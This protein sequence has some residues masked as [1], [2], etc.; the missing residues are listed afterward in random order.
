MLVLRICTA[1]MLLVLS[2]SL[3]WAAKVPYH[4]KCQS[5]CISICQP[6]RQG[7]R[8]VSSSG[9]WGAFSTFLQLRVCEGPRGRPSRQ[10]RPGPQG[11]DEMPGQV[12]ATGSFH[13]NLL[14]I[15]IKGLSCACFTIERGKH[16][17][18]ARGRPSQAGSQFG[19][20]KRTISSASC[21]LQ[22]PSSQIPPFFLDLRLPSSKAIQWAIQNGYE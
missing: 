20:T 16:R 1:I 13:S 7:V 17:P 5:Y 22:W 6:T 4:R 12:Y 8:C 21:L 18:F 9:S 10:C 2:A 3:A 14:H 19:D 11:G 15:V